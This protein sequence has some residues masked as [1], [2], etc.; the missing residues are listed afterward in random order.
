MKRSL[1][2][3]FIFFLLFTLNACKEKD[4]DDKDP[5]LS[6]WSFVSI[7]INP[8]VVFIVDQEDTLRS[9]DLVNRDAEIV[10][11][12][13][14]LVGE[15]IDDALASWV[16]GVVRCGYLEPDVILQSVTIASRHA[17]ETQDTAFR[18]R[19]GSIIEET[20]APFG[21]AAIVLDS[22]D[23]DASVQNLMQTHDILEGHARIVG[24]YL[25][26]FADQTLEDT[27]QKDV[28]ELIHDLSE[29]H[30]SGL[31]HYRDEL[32]TEAKTIKD[33]LID[34]ARDILAIHAQAIQSGLKVKPDPTDAK[35][36]FVASY[37]ENR[38]DYEDKVRSR[39]DFA[40][41]IS[42]G[43]TPSHMVGEY[44][45][46]VAD[47]D[48]G[49]IITY[50]VYTLNDDG[51]YT[52]R[53]SWTTPISMGSQTSTGTGEGTWGVVDGALVLTNPSG[54][55]TIFSI[56]ASRIAYDWPLGFQGRDGMVTRYFKKT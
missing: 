52:Y 50:E 9:L 34:D 49:F 37:E 25:D 11:A 6:E 13:M 28:A 45:Y 54:H 35:D 46:E 5:V 16:E 3:F 8:E 10:Y 47:G 14:D 18:E 27:L 2:S 51:T 55:E 4:S 48:I 30:A 24:H 26:H 1:W 22:K 44:V 15:T 12:D 53:Y 56:Y 23:V 38:T 17:D 7:E 19:I 43:L 39:L 36:D 21:I 40:E 33:Q 41:Q 31:R 42:K 29:S 32:E 20:L